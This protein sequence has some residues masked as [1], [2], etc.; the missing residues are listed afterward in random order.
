MSRMSA[1]D[2]AWLRMDRPTNLMVV[3]SVLLFEEPLPW[4]DLR[5]L[6]GERLVRRHPRFRQ[7]VVPGALPLLP[8]GWEPDEDFALEHHLHHL[9]L[10]APGDDQA[11]RELIAE[12]V[13]T[14]LD[15][16]RPLWSMYLVDGHGEGCALIARMHHCIA[17][18]IALAEVLLSLTDEHAAERAERR[19]ATALAAG[20]ISLARAA[21]ATA[22]EQ[23]VAIVR[24]PGHA[25]ELAGAVA[26]DTATA[27]RV[28][29]TPADPASPLKGAP[30]VSRRVAWTQPISL[31]LVRRIGHD[32]GATVNDVLLAAVSGALRQH[33]QR[34]GRPTGE[35]QALVPFNLRPLD[36]PVSAELGNRF[37]LVYLP[38]PVGTSSGYRRLATVHRRMDAIKRSR[39]GPV[40]FEL[41]SA[42]GM[43]PTRVERWIVDRLSGKST[44]V[45]TNV[46]GPRQPVSLAGVPVRSVLVWA[47]TSGRVG[48]SVSIFSYRGEVTVGLM[49]DAAHVAKPDTIVRGVEREVR[50]LAKLKPTVTYE[51]ARW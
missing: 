17:D 5:A 32:H 4:E 21:L 34:R 33:L 42:V 23:G 28:L 48:M 19:T 31:E 12:L 51:G 44:A 47:P 8:P 41:L 18:G 15:R 14:P 9:A 50:A 46:P 22:V 36:E 49:S 30:G 45:M 27:L 11:L 29:L 10:P 35:L 13:V 39:T 3:N 1:A 24:R 6:I 37:G 2:A 38:L 40:S 7:R 20:P 25:V 43:T 26:A 16:A